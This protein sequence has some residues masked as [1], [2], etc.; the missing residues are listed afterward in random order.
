MGRIWGTQESETDTL[1]TEEEN[2][3]EEQLELDCRC[4]KDGRTGETDEG[5]VENKG[6]DASRCLEEDEGG[7][8]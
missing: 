8:A 3:G 5:L 6:E 2:R 1:T 4:A 7:D